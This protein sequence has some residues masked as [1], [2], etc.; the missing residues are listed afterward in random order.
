M[1]FLSVAA[2]LGAAVLTMAAAPVPQAPLDWAYPDGRGARP[3]GGWDTHRA[4]STPGGTVT[5]TEAETR[6]FFKVPDWRPKSHPPMPPVVASGRKPDVYACGFCHLPGGEGRPENATLA[7][8]PQGYI[9]RQVRAFATGAR[10][11]VVHDWR[12]SALMSGVARAATPAEI[13]AA[14]DYFSRLKFTSRV[15][16]VEAASLPTPK[17]MNALFV[18]GTGKT[19]EPLGARIVEAPSSMER[20]ERRDAQVEF[21]AYVPVGSLQRGAA[22]AK[23]GG[24]VQA[25]AGCHGGGPKGGGLGP[26]LAGRSPSY[27]FRQLYGFQSG[28]RA[29]PDAT[30][31]KAVVAHLTPSDMIALA[32]YAGAQ[33]P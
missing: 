32:A 19:V 6:D 3:S 12:P 25:C 13:N 9:V 20:F 24:G 22:L 29:D 14:A 31:M 8:L 10:T 21:T 15:R 4:L 30:P 5:F 1:R 26:P 23:G 11:S 2:G 18:S 33:R 28:A 16:V 27:L 7:G 17:A